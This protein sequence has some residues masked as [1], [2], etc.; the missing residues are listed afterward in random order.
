M[1]VKLKLIALLALILIATSASALTLTTF[2][3]SQT[4][5]SI[6]VSGGSSNSVA[7]L[8]PKRSTINSATVNLTASYNNSGVFISNGY[9][10]D[11]ASTASSWTNFTTGPTPWALQA[12]GGGVGNELIK[13]SQP[14][15]ENSSMYSYV[16]T[17]ISQINPGSLFF[18]RYNGAATQTPGSVLTQL[19]F[20]NGTFIAT[21]RNDTYTAP[22]GLFDRTSLNLS[23]FG[24]LNNIMLVFNESKTSSLR[25]VFG[26]SEVSLNS[27]TSNVSGFIGLSNN[28]FYSKPGTFYD[29]LI[30]EDHS[31]PEITSNFSGQIQNYLANCTEDIN[32]FCTVPLSFSSNTNGTLVLNALEVNYT[33]LSGLYTSVIDLTTLGIIN[34]TTLTVTNGTNQVVTVLDFTSNS[35]VFIPFANLPAGNVQ[36][37]YSKPG[38]Q[39][40]NFFINITEGLV[41][42]ITAYLLNTTAPN[43][44]QISFNVV[45]SVQ[46]PIPG[47]IISVYQPINNTYVLVGQAQTDS[48]GFAAL[49]LDQTV[50]YILNVSAT[51]FNPISQ[52]LRPTLLSYIIQLQPS[53]ANSF[54]LPLSGMN[55]TLLPPAITHVIETFIFDLQVTD[56]SITNQ[57]L[58]LTDAN[59]NILNQTSNNTASNG[60]RLNFTYNMTNV[61]VSLFLTGTFTRT[62]VGTYSQS[63]NY[64]A[65][66]FNFNT[67]NSS[68]STI[69]DDFTDPAHPEN[70]PPAFFMGIVAFIL[71]TIF[72]ITVYRY[73]GNAATSAFAGFLFL[74]LLT[75]FGFITWSLWL[76][77]LVTI[78]GLVYFVFRG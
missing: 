21:I 76:L 49:F 37:I 66:A 51:G 33:S 8:L 24:T 67:T 12:A 71:T 20:Q 70:R 59:G 47:A 38:Y 50:T 65:T 45:N 42:N 39:S 48:S 61:N 2:N 57:I 29:R 60:T 13:I 41:S 77:L 43:V 19:Y 15:V 1:E 36:L 7:I 22:S 46:S 3:N 35:T 26:L 11:S 14:I 6:Y 4:S 75:F 23:S 56:G 5:D 69:I 58:T 31:S 16:S 34:A 25:F 72:T 9:F 68:I 27:T 55:F 30:A 32:G 78:V 40:T 17:N 62:G 54:P 74:T 44:A 64:P 53:N 52:T 28:T 63:I 18:S 10:A 73:A